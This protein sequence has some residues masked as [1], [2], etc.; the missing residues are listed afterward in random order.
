MNC[1][2]FL[3]KGLPTRNVTVAPKSVQLQ[4]ASLQNEFQ[5]YF[6]AS[7]YLEAN[8]YDPA[9]AQCNCTTWNL[10]NLFGAIS[11]RQSLALGVSRPLTGPVC[12]PL[13]LDSCSLAS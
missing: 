3:R 2:S 4:G 11:L 6:I 8:I 7:D 10:S 5:T 12:F 1:V 13:Y 9:E